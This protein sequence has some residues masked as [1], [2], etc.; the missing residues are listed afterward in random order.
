MQKDRDIALA[1]GC[2]DFLTKPIEEEKLLKA[3]NRFLIDDI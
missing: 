3:L 2:D 1:A